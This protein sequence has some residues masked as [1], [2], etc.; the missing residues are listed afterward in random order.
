LF[1]F[2]VDRRFGI[3]IGIVEIWIVVRI[4]IRTRI[5]RRVRP[6]WIVVREPK[7]SADE[8]ARTSEVVKVTSVEVAPTEAAS[9][10]E[11]TAPGMSTTRGAKSA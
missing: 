10:A 7:V 8:D 9:A 6:I 4:V 11:M 1:R 3:S 2:L 5:I